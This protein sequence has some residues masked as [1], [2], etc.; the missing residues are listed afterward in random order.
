MT[1]LMGTGM[2]PLED[3]YD[4]RTIQELLGHK[5]IK[6]TMVYTHVLQQGGM[7]VKSPADRLG[8]MS[9]LGRLLR[10]RSGASHFSNCMAAYRCLYGSYHS[11]YRE[12]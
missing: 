1:I 4:I 5:D 10:C 9:N 2:S 8:V 11:K 6:T 3:G 12:G 7:G